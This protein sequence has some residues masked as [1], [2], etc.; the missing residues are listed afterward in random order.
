[1]LT[2]SIIGAGDEAGP[3]AGGA[4]RRGRGHHGTLLLLYYSLLGGVR[5]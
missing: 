5:G 2:N 1:V 3:G 4:P